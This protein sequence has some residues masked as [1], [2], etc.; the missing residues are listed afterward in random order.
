[1]IVNLSPRD[2]PLNDLA[3]IC[4]EK[5]LRLV[6]AHSHNPTV[7]VVT[8]KHL[9]NNCCLVLFIAALALAPRLV[10]GYCIEIRCLV[11]RAPP[12]KLFLDLSALLDPQF[13]EVV[14]VATH[15]GP[16][17]VAIVVTTS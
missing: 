7:E 13:E 17:R 9:L 10:T 16:E 3:P 15:R 4:V 12:C 11:D 1:M 5:H 6:E 2:V 14:V 8:L